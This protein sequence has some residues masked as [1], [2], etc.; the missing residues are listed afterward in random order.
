M[1]PMKIIVRAPNWVGDSILALP[2]I[3]SL[4]DNYP[5]A[6]IWVG[7]RDW[8]LDLFPAGDGLAGSI[9]LPNR[10]DLKTLKGAGRELRTRSFDAGLLLT[11]S[12]SSALLFV[13]GKI[14]ERWGYA[15]D[16]RGP[17]LTKRV[18]RRAP[19]PDPHQVHYYLRLIS[20]LGLKTRP[21]KIK[22]TLSTAE[23]RAAR[24]RLR[25]L[26]VR[27]G[28]PLVV[29][30]PGASYGPAKR[31]LPERFAAAADKLRARHKAEILLV[32]SSD[33]TDLAEKVAAGMKK[34]PYVLTGRTTLRE[35]LGLLGQAG[36]LLTND[37]GPMH[38]ANA[39]GVPVVAVFGPTDPRRTGPIQPPF[40]VLKKDAACWPCLY[41]KCP[42]DHRCMAAIGVD[43]VFEACRQFL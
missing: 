10:A 2:A 32:G 26:G 6:E 30:D 4:H 3:A 1:C 24:E 18:A 23:T 13:M 22:L 7:S 33:E 28:R 42:Y 9:A 21:P 29:I 38:M 17:L 27:A 36:L 11:N 5:G 8:V 12:F 25:G 20:G 40:A 35:L 16:G 31:W 43:E 39:L 37:S 41:R 34:R 15:A 14:P 19:G